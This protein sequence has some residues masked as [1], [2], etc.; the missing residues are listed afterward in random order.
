CGRTSDAD[1]ISRV[2][3]GWLGDGSSATAGGACKAISSRSA[4]SLAYSPQDGFAPCRNVVTRCPPA[5][6]PGALLGFTSALALVTCTGNC[7]ANHTR[8][9]RVGAHR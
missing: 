9:S 4:A 6:L 3:L 8:L 7:R 5:R 2:V 1:R